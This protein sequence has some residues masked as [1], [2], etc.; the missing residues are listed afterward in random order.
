[1]DKIGRKYKKGDTLTAYAFLSPWII[2][3]LLFSGVP[4]IASFALGFTKW[5][6]VS[7]PQ[8]IGLANYV[9][10]FT[11]GSNFW[12]V[13]KITAVFTVASVVVTMAWALFLATLLNS[14]LQGMGIF[15][16][17][18][19]IPAV[20]PSVALAFAFQLLYNKEIGIIN[21][22][23]SLFGVK[24]GPNWLMDQNYVIPSIV[25]VCLYTYTTGQMMLIFNASLKEVPQELYEAC[26]IDGATGL[27]KF[28]YVTL[29][30]ISPVIL[31]NLVIATVNA[32]NSSFSIIYPLT[33]GGPGD[34]SRVIGIDI[35]D[36]AFKR[37]RMGYAAA[38]STV[39]FVIVA[40]ISWFQ[41][42]L[43]KKYVHYEAE[44]GV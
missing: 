1:M 36:N 9:E 10:M 8:F 29:P 24:D 22:F 38:L 2:G 13:M 26:D 43:S 20:M 27:Q 23:L 5:D 40:A 35:Y 17:F 42:R 28:I 18:Y 44:E 32:L 39:L 37:F 15:Q 4:I 16:F 33:F 12:N 41:F 25:F 6:F 19:F 11:P 30:S 7:P 21:Y 31:F 34:A 3:F 14:K